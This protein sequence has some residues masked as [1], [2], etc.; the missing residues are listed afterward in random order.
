[1]KY[2]DK[3]Y[4]QELTKKQQFEIMKTDFFVKKE[5]NVEEV[6]NAYILPAIPSNT[7]DTWYKGGV[8]DSNKNYVLSSGEYAVGEK[9]RFSGVYE[10]DENDVEYIDEEVYYLNYYIYQWGHYLLDVIGRLWYIINK[11]D[12]KIVYVR[13]LNDD[14]PLK[15]NY[16]QLLELLGV[17]KNRLVQIT[18]ITK[19]KKVIIPD[20]SI[21]ITSF[22]TK[23]YQQIIDGVVDKA[24]DGYE[25]KKNRK[26]YCSRIDFSVAS[27]KEFGEEKIEKIFKN[28]GY[29]IIHME[30]LNLI[31][32][33]R[34]LNECSEIVCLSGTLVHN[35]MFIKNENCSFTILNKTYKIN[36]NIYLSNQLSKAC[37][38]FV[39]IYLSPLPI[40]IGKGPFL[41]TVTN[42][43]IKYCKDRNLDIDTRDTKVSIK[44][45]LEYFYKYFV[46][47]RKKILNGKA[48]S[49]TGFEE[50]DVSS[51]NIRKHF[52]KEI[53]KLNK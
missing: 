38:T 26:I 9:S 52:I 14:C 21:C 33:I 11:T 10:F 49:D 4:L 51:S 29:E 39:D 35:A 16:L 37:F 7:N 12:R 41:I 45:L 36:P 24:L 22:F 6:E 46:R 28:N 19:F 2:S 34:T 25:L 1:M 3:Q 30:K 13:K 42:E 27:N 50:Y 40:S 20:T 18:K 32:Q 47:Y 53:T 17:D 5:L 43:M 8:V 23:E 44:V 48:I 15:G 31:Q